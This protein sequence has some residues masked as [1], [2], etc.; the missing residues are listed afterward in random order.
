METRTVRKHQN[1]SAQQLDILTALLSRAFFVYGN[2]HSDGLSNKPIVMAEIQLSFGRKGRLATP[3]IDLTPMVDLGFL[4][5]T[6]FMYT[7]TM[8]EAK[9]MDINM[10]FNPPPPGTEMPFIES[11]TITIIP[12]DAHQFFYYEGTAK[13]ETDL[14]KLSLAE[15][16]NT[17]LNKQH[18]LRINTIARTEEARKIH[19]IIKPDDRSKYEDIVGILDEM[20]INAVPYYAIAD[21]TVEEKQ[22]LTK[23]LQ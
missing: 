16:R 18:A 5:I 8:T 17:I 21:L 13:N 19:V 7:T 15:V 1:S 14:R 20:T 4:L 22:W 6:F 11:A 9:M 10:P 2:L 3:R 23:R 12:S